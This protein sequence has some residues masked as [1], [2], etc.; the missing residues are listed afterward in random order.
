MKKRIAV[1]K[2]TKQGYTFISEHEFSAGGENVRLTEWLEADFVE[3]PAKEV[4]EGEVAALDRLAEEVRAAAHDKL[5][6]IE[7]RKAELLALPAPQ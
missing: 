7:R 3:L 2:D 5:Q 6:F 1:W 4:V